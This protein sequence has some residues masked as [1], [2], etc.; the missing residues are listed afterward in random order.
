MTSFS[1]LI[2]S[3]LVG[4]DGGVYEGV[5]WHIQG[6][7][8]YGYNDIALGIAFMGNFVGK[9]RAWAEG[10][11]DKVLHGMLGKHGAAF[12]A[13]WCLAVPMGHFS[14]E[15]DSQ[16][17]MTV[18]RNPSRQKICLQSPNPIPRSI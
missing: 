11:G 7:H 4:Q 10:S 6:S 9:E 3:F 15:V 13:L 16:Y 2:S 12:A 1:L 14:F 8:T 18:I 5:G 17:M